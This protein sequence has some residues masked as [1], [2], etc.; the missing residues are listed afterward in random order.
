MK[1]YKRIDMIC[2]A[3]SFVSDLFNR[4]IVV[5]DIGTDHGFV[6]EQVSKF[7][8]VQKVIA[9]DISEKSLS[10]LTALIKRR[11]LEKIDTKVGDGLEPIKQADVSVIAGI[12]GL[13]ISKIIKNQNKN[14]DGENKCNI[15]ILQPAQNIVELRKWAI[16]KNYKI[17]KD[18]T[19]EDNEQF[20]A[21]LIIDISQFEENKKSIYNYWIGRDCSENKQEFDKFILYLTDYLSFLDNVSLERI[22]QDKVLLQ[23]YK[24]KKLITKLK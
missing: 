16:S 15:F 12:G 7:E 6:A 18:I 8:N 9:T 2:S 24:L 3:V 22:K 19:F 20:Y 14:D 23:K 1:T 4:K 13:E 17:L 5:A 11:K 21:I 10:K